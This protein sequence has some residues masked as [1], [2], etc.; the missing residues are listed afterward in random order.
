MIFFLFICL[1]ILKGQLLSLTPQRVNIP[2]MPPIATPLITQRSDKNAKIQSL[3][4][5]LVKG[6]KTENNL[7]QLLLY[8]KRRHN[9][10]RKW[11]ADQWTTG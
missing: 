5:H 2:A 7:P 3:E 1:V 4:K 10:Q 8:N 11:G 9:S 6:A